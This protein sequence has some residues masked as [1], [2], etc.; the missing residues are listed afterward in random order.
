MLVRIYHVRQRKRNSAY[1]SQSFQVERAILCKRA[2]QDVRVKH[3][4]ARTTYVR[5]VRTGY[6]LSEGNG[7]KQC[8]NKHQASETQATHARRTMQTR[9]NQ[10]LTTTNT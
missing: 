1:V 7:S 4:P 5:R 2:K 3:C 10:P 8:S 9:R 6:D